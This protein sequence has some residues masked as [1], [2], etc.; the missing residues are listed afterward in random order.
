MHLNFLL[1]KTVDIVIVFRMA[2]TMKHPQMLPD[3]EE[4]ERQ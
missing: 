3:S 4:L 1:L 2:Q